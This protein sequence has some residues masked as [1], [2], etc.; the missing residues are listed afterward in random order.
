MKKKQAFK[1]AKLV[2]DE[3]RV[4]FFILQT[5]F[6]N[7]SIINYD[8]DFREKNLYLEFYFDLFYY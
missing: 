3:I 8:K 1:K 7:W 2:E 6:W 5:I 4:I